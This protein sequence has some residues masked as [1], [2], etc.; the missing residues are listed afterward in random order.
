ME[1]SQ[2]HV[3]L[4][5]VVDQL[6]TDDAAVGTE[7]AGHRLLELWKARGGAYSWHS[8]P[9]WHGT[10][11]YAAELVGIGLLERHVGMA[12]FRRPDQ[13]AET[14]KQFWLTLTDAGRQVLN[15]HEA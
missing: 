12:S 15:G 1:L 3:D 6:E 9:P 2:E 14:V 11:P 10:R 13:P 7:V 4:L 5:R 8:S